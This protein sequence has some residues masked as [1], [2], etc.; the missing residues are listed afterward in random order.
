VGAVAGATGEGEADVELAGEPL[1]VASDGAYV[2]PILPRNEKLFIA[3]GFN[4]CGLTHSAGPQQA[5]FGWADG[6]GPRFR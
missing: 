1:V 2:D 6:F 5:G 3:T 4:R